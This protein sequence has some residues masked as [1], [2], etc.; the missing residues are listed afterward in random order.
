M[1]TGIDREWIVALCGRERSLGALKIACWLSKHAV[2]AGWRIQGVHVITRD[3]AVVREH[4]ELIESARRRVREEIAA[5]VDEVAS[6][7]TLG[8][9]EIIEAETAVDG[10]REMVRNEGI[11]G[12]VIG[13]PT[14]EHALV[15]LGRTARRLLRECEVP[16]VVAGPELDPSVLESGPVLMTV[17][18]TDRCARATA[19]ARE[20]ADG[21][22]RP[23]RLVHVAGIPEWAGIETVVPEPTEHRL[24]TIHERA[25][26]TLA[27]WQADH[28]LE[29]LPADAVL[30]PRLVERLLEHA[31]SVG[32]CMLVCGTRPHDVHEQT[33]EPGLSDELASTSPWP[34]AVVPAC[35]ASSVDLDHPDPADHAEP[36][37]ELEPE[38]ESNPSPIDLD[39]LRSEGE[40]MVTEDAKL[41]AEHLGELPRHPPSI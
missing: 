3:S 12:L 26:L 8:A 31:R 32:A 21:L 16:V 13:R 17:G 39:I 41:S 11:Q 34:V 20:L 35:A 30:G 5:L 24:E 38:L 27:Q 29:S 36:E 22:G 7:Y 10:L 40:G 15:R 28:G 2:H 4:P 37:P 9:I 25:E 6:G 23:L 1:K 18:L 33:A 14:S 19:W